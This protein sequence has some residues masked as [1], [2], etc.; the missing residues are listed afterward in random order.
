MEGELAKQLKFARDWNSACK[1]I[2]QRRFPA[3]RA[4]FVGMRCTS[5]EGVGLLELDGGQEGG[6]VCLFV[7]LLVCACE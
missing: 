1:S 5:Q 4:V 3:A 6:L 2:Q 7:S